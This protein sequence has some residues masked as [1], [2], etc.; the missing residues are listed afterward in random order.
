MLCKGFSSPDAVFFCTTVAKLVTKK[1]LNLTA[2]T[3]F[4]AHEEF[5]VPDVFDNFI[6]SWKEWMRSGA[7]SAQALPKWYL[8]AH[9]TGKVNEKKL[10]KYIAV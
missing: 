10:F 7:F 2:A 6:K 8:E 9:L 5:V 1:F 4:R 3:F